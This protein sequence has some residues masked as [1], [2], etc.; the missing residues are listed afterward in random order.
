MSVW[1]SG[2]EP[3]RQAYTEITIESFLLRF[4][5]LAAIFLFALLIAY[6]AH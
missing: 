5:F 2:H 3:P 1:W 6:F 4:A